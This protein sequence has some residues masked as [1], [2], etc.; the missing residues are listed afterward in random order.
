MSPRYIDERDSS[1]FT[2]GSRRRGTLDP[3]YLHSGEL[4]CRDCCLIER[5]MLENAIDREYIEDEFAYCGDP[6][7]C[8]F[9]GSYERY[10]PR[11][12]YIT[13]S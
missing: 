4:C 12:W 9:S 8:Y 7:C 3:S 5:D 2:V 1:Y 6:D 11:E 13:Q 10:E